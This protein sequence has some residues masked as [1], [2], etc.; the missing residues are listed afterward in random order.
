VASSIDPA[1]RPV[2]REPARPRPLGAGARLRGD[3][4]GR[5]RHLERA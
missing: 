4:A 3:R 2:G 5:H 1:A